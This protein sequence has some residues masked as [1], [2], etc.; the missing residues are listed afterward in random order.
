MKKEVIVL[1]LLG[2]L[3]VSPLVLAQEQVKV[4]SGFNRFVDNV[5][6]FFSGGDNKVMLALEIREKEVNSAM[7]NSRNGEDEEAEKNLKRARERLKFVQER[8]ST[9]TAED[10]GLNVDEI[11]GDINKE[12]DLSNSFGIYV[13]EERKTQL[14]AELVIKVEGNE[15]LTEVKVAEE[16]LGQINNV[17]KEWVVENSFGEEGEEGDEGLIREIK[18]DIDSGDY[19][20]D[21]GLTPEIKTYTDKV[22]TEEI[23]DK[24]DDGG[25]APG[26][27]NEAPGDTIV[28]G[29]N[30]VID[31]V[32]DVIETGDNVVSTGVD[33]DATPKTPVPTDGSI[34][35]KKTKYGETRYHW[36]SK[37]DC[38]DPGNIKG[39]V[40]DNNVCLSLGSAILDQEDPESWGSIEGGVPEPCVAQ[41]AYD[42]E[43]CERIMEMLEICCRKIVDGEVVY[44]WIPGKICVSPYGDRVDEDACL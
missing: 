37:D 28:S 31:S 2:I 21:D 29:G 16:K 10:V 3:L 24:I 1:L 15:R 20:E 9:D 13:L 8:V 18:T 7:I 44:E 36:D 40:M 39:D 35:C 23:L 6:M 32:D 12:K 19:G 5:K 26:T 11:I 25:M 27:N 42:D 43:A 17:I 33:P 38:L 4:Y 14:T 41:G 34:C 30:N 22:G